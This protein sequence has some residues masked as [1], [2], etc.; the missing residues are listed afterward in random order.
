MTIGT[1]SILFGAHAFY[2]HPW[3]LA[4]AWTRLYGF[5]WDPRLWFA[6]FLHDIGYWGKPNMDG[7]EGEAH[8]IAGALIM[9]KLFGDEWGEFTLLHSRWFA[10]RM[11]KR[12]S[13]LCVADK[14]AICLTPA[15]LYLPMVLATGELGEYMGLKREKKY[16]DLG[17]DHSTPRAWFDSVKAYLAEWVRVHQ[18]VDH[19]DLWMNGVD[20][21]ET[22]MAR[23]PGYLD[24][25]FEPGRYVV[26]KR[27]GEPADPSAKYLVLRYDQ[28][29]H[30]VVAC[31]TYAVSVRPQNPE[32]AAGVTE[33]VRNELGLDEAGFDSK[34]GEF[35]R[36]TGRAL[37]LGPETPQGVAFAVEMD[38]P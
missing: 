36:V 17:F 5:P 16:V 30:A 13:K 2:L 33:A 31:L 8:P 28:D 25:G 9:T 35:L 32:L 11:N 6:F 10:T 18:N 1:R 20:L 21:K 37:D 34:Y 27:G 15:W 19:D 3:F 24:G 23:M 26:A 7:P 4:L 38:P 22:T 14:Y 12:Y 29:P